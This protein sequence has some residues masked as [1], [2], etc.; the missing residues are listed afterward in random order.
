LSSAIVGCNWLYHHQ[1]D[2]YLSNPVKA[3]NGR[4]GQSGVATLMKNGL[5]NYDGSRETVING[6]YKP[7][8]GPG[9]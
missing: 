4:K 9:P 3:S 1:T 7:K 5:E 6:I 2:L 8:G